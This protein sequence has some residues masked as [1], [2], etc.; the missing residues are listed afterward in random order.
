MCEGNLYRQNI[1]DSSW[2]YER[3]VAAHLP[4]ALPTTKLTTIFDAKPA[5]H[6]AMVPRLAV[7]ADVR[8]N[9]VYTA[10]FKSLKYP[11]IP[12]SPKTFKEWCGQ[13]P[14]AEE[15]LLHFITYKSCDEKDLIKYL[16]L[17]CIIYI[18]TDGGKREHGGSSFSWIICSLERK[19]MVV[20]SGPVDGW[21]RC[22]R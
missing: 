20:N 15:C 22:Q 19:T 5:T 1:I 14:P 12:P 9:L 11:L 3:Y 17:D 21:H 7:P 4:E 13:L 6:S 18:G 16:Q 8:G 10:D 2:N